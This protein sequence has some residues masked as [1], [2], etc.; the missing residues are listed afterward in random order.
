MATKRDSRGRF[1]KGKKAPLPAGKGK[2]IWPARK[3]K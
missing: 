3:G 1:V 2:P